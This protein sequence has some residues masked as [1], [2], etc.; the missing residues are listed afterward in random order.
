MCCFIKAI[1]K[2]FI[3][4]GSFSNVLLHCGN[5]RNNLLGMCNE[6]IKNDRLLIMLI[7][8]C[9][10]LG[11]NN[12]FS[13]FSKKRTVFESKVSKRLFLFAEKSTRCGF[14]KARRCCNT[15]RPDGLR[16]TYMY[17]RISLIYTRP[18]DQMVCVTR[19]CTVGSLWSARPDLYTS[20]I[21]LEEPE[22]T[23]LDT[24]TSG[25]QS[26]RDLSLV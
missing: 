26:P 18:A 17:C 19:T 23:E 11:D 7:Q 22:L 2:T 6:K 13:P 21:R 4:L 8:Q 16:Y 5:L 25:S 3:P 10:A 20:R 12:F 1:A 14:T 24:T 9:V 15:F